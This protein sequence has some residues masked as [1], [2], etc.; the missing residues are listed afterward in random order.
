MICRDGVYMVFWGEDIDFRSSGFSLLSSNPSCKR[1]LSSSCHN[2]CRLDPD[3]DCD[4]T[5]VGFSHSSQKS[6]VATAKY[7]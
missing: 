3:F 1:G 6:V 2:F 7:A 4:A 5:W